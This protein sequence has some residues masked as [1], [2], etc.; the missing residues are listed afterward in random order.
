MVLTIV[1]VAALAMVAFG[2]GF[3]STVTVTV[4]TPR[5]GL[6][7]DP[8]AKVRMR[9]VEIGRVASVDYRSDRV[10]LR[11]A[12]DPE[13]L[14]RVPANARV[15]IRSTTVFGAK[16]VDFVAPS[17]PSTTSLRPGAL[18]RADAVTVEWN[19]LFERLS[20]ILAKVEPGQLNAT[21]AALGTALE[22]RGDRLGE[23]LARTDS[24]L[25]EINPSLP[26][27]QRD[28][29]STG[30]VGDLYADAAADLL[31]TVDNATQTSATVADYQR[32]LDALLLDLIGLAGTGRDVLSENARS[33]GTA[34]DLLRPTASLLHTYSPV[35]TCVIVGIAQVM[36]EAE[37]FV[38]GLQPGAAFNTNFMFP[39]EPYQYPNDLPKVNATGGPHCEGV[40]D[41]VRGSHS[42]YLVTDTNQGAPY[43]PP[44]VNS[45]KT[46]LVFEILFAGLDSGF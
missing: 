7:L 3:A 2:G 29:A 44:T 9:G 21:L 28:M 34:L 38:G 8:D 41:P 14:R 13:A 40:V 6:V 16:Y 31:R 1:T 11:L 45:P 24:V 37:G 39:S 30:R 26:A 35:L 33:F 5:S 27:F 19:T 15:E 43:V 4:E 46:P 10:A 42:D 20:T 36:P 32:E 23:L 17:A 18:V 12:L 25:R 22:G